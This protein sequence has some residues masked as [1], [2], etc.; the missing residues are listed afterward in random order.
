MNNPREVIILGTGPIGLLKCW[1][2]LKNNS[3]KKITLIDSKSVIGGA[4]FFEK[5]KKHELETG[6][7]IWS[8]CPSVYNFI[9]TELGIELAPFSTKPIFKKNNWEIPYSLKNT[10]DSYLYLLKRLIKLDFK[11]FSK[12]KKSPKYYLNPFGKDNLYP[13]NGSI[14]LIKTLFSQISKDSRAN[15]ILNTEITSINIKE[16]VIVSSD[17]LEINADK[18]FLTSTIKLNELL[19]NKKKINYKNEPVNYIHYKVILDSKPLKEAS[20]Y[21]IT[22]DKIIHRIA[23][24]SYQTN[25]DSQILLIAVFEK[26]IITQNTNQITEHIT[27]YLIKHK[28]ISN[29][30]KIDLDKIYEFPTYYSNQKTRDEINSLDQS[31]IELLH[32]TD[33]MYGMHEL[34]KNENII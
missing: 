17:G 32:S 18:I 9:S 19:V 8:Y 7:H 10:I 23:D 24:I 12:I 15:I 5:Q 13:R 29:R 28:I 31:K 6:C 34:L 3:I 2:L 33:L 22:N 14:E 20:Y 30:T 27:N 16:K 4:W 1:I 25:N 26:S 21:R 11:V